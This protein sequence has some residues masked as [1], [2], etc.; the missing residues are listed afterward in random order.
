MTTSE[1]GR[2]GR[3]FHP[4]GC[5]GNPGPD[6]ASLRAAEGSSASLLAST[7][8]GFRVL[9][10]I[11]SALGRGDA[12]QNMNP[13]TSS[14]WPHSAGSSR[15]HI[16]RVARRPELP[17]G[18]YYP[19]H[20]V[21][22]DQPTTG[23][24][25][26]VVVVRPSAGRLV[27]GWSLAAFGII[28]ALAGLGDAETQYLMP[29][30]GALCACMGVAVA[31]SRATAT[32]DEVRYRYGFIRRKVLASEVESVGVGPGNGRSFVAIRLNRHAGKPVRLIGVQRQDSDSARRVLREEAERVAAV[33][34]CPAD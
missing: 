1:F 18:G 2:P 4:S 23:D 29:A 10:A 31:T 6:S 8:S 7:A 11:A 33:L 12:E 25:R 20:T 9:T 30:F 26:S 28:F 15:V 34:G 22:V 21:A 32:Q 13:T 19:R 16:R 3:E 27:L 17:K 5:V 14:R 24:G